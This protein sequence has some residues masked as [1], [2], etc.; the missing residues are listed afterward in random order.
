VT[1]VLLIGLLALLGGRFLVVPM[2]TAR[3]RGQLRPPVL[4]RHDKGDHAR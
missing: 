1:V 4:P 3:S 2:M